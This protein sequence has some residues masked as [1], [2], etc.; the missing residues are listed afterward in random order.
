MKH[1]SHPIIGDATHGR[2]RHNRYFKETLGCDRLLLACVGL[3]FRH[4]VTGEKV[5]VGDTVKDQFA[6]L[7]ERF[8]WSYSPERSDA[9][10]PIAS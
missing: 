10:R 7:L 8:G 4:P 3:A 6:E 9:L 1:I 5:S 2:G